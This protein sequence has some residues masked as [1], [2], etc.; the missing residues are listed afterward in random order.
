M[1]VDADRGSIRW[2]LARNDGAQGGM[3]VQVVPH[4][5]YDSARAKIAANLSWLLCKA[6]GTDDVPTDLRDPFYTDQYEQE[7]I[8]PP[9]IHLLLSSELYCIVCSLLQPEHASSF[10][11]HTSVLQALSKK[12]I[13]VLNDNNTLIS[14][15]ELASAP[16]QMSSHIHL[17][18]ALMTAYTEEMISIEKVMSAVKSFSESSDSAELPSD[19]EAAMVLW[20]NKVIKKLRT[21]PQTKMK[22]KH[23]FLDPPDQQKVQYK[24]HL[25]GQAQQ[26]DYLENLSDFVRNGSAVLAVVHF[27]CPELITLEDICLEEALSTAESEFNTETLRDFSDE[28]LNRCFHLSPAD[29]LHSPPA[30]KS[31]MMQYIAELFWIFETVKPDF[32]QPRETSEI[33]DVRRPWHLQTPKAPKHRSWTLKSKESIAEATSPE[34][35]YKTSSNPWCQREHRVV[36]DNTVGHRR[37]SNSI[38]QPSGSQSTTFPWSRNRERSLSQ[39]ML[40][41]LKFPM[42]EDANRIS[43]IHSHSKPCLASTSMSTT[44]EH[45]QAA[46]RPHRLSGQSLLDHIRFEDEEAEIE[47]EEFVAIIDPS[48]LPRHRQRELQQKDWDSTMASRIT[49]SGAS[50]VLAPPLFSEECT[51]DKYYLEPLMPAIRK[52]AKEKSVSVKKEEECGEAM[53]KFRGSGSGVH[54]TAQQ[55]DSKYKSNVSLPSSKP[56]PGFYLHSLEEPK[57]DSLLSSFEASNDSDSDLENFPEDNENQ[58]HPRSNI[59][60]EDRYFTNEQSHFTEGESAKLGKDLEMNEW[61]DKEDHSGC[62]S[63]CVSVGSTNCNTSS[64]IGLKMT[65]FVEKRRLKLGRDGFSSAGTTPDDSETAPCPPWQMKNSRSSGSLDKEPCLVS[66][67]NVT[68][69]SEFLELHMELEE[70]RQAIECQKKKMENLSAQQRLKLGKAAFL[71]IVRREP[72]RSDTLPLPLKQQ[73]SVLKAVDQNQ[74]NKQNCKD[75][76]CLEALKM[77]QNNESL[78]ITDNKLS[79][80]SGQNLNVCSRS[81]DTLNEAIATIQQQILQ[82]S[83]QQDILIKNS[84]VS[85]S[86]LKLETNTT[87]TKKSSV[88][89]LPPANVSDESSPFSSQPKLN[90]SRKQA[91]FVTL[92]NTNEEVEKEAVEECKTKQDKME[93]CS[94]KDCNVINQ[95][96]TEDKVELLSTA[97]N[98]PLDPSSPGAGDQTEKLETQAVSSET[99]VADNLDKTPR[100][101]AQLVEVDLSEI[102][103]PNSSADPENEQK[104]VLGFFFKDEERPDEMAKRRAAFL[105]KQQRKA[106]EAKVRKQQQEVESELKRD[107]ARR[108]AEEEQIRKEEEKARREF[109]KQEYLRRKQQILTEEQGQVTSLPRRKSRKSRPKSLHREG[110]SSLFKGTTTPDLGNSRR[111]STLSLATEVESVFSVE[112]HCAES[113][114]SMDFSVL[115]RASSR[116]MDRDWENGSI[117]SSITSTEYTGP[118]L[119]KEPSSKSNK[120]IIINAIAHCCLAGKVNEAQKNVIL[121]E[122]DKCES[123]HLI[124]LFRDGGCQFRAIYSYF[125]DTEEIIKVTGTGPRNISP[126]MIDKLYKYSSDRKQFSVIPAKS[127]SVS[128]DA[129]TIHSHLWQI[130]R[131]GSARRK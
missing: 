1:N 34:I 31:N 26:H 22:T 129:L 89:S 90:L 131:P 107:E 99:E 67:N 18:D 12:D 8:K 93:N 123:N 21:F 111:G 115:S 78:L 62:S 23:H 122:L 27:Y 61:D 113:V 76:F 121:E 20:I 85:P 110:P 55:S 72:G 84:S 30:L 59:R 60:S 38:T 43:F 119:F 120:P 49:S 9:I 41:A 125:P 118:K 4:E 52:P 105:I 91:F 36:K 13:Y 7:H 37:W 47:E 128:I 75:D 65:S 98:T 130:K 88:E 80:S 46:G 100:I 35:C 33:K 6:F 74:V 103:E 127:V 28:F 66:R 58:L 14:E 81:I 77:I 87:P 51:M 19:L 73:S 63:P 95:Q 54:R 48:K 17:I 83:Q 92:D 2:R 79:P 10:Q 42:K 11:N 71:N 116:N 64:G 3:D 70:R 86:K 112:S 45:M 57:G 109:I 69:S 104:N 16:I 56:S 32:V 15:L 97:S 44:P 29:M 102:K 114:S 39:P 108:K 50:G 53:R 25:S 124:I 96:H 106:E 94:V 24:D 82:L 68:V 40:N 101:K 5:L 126:K 117:A